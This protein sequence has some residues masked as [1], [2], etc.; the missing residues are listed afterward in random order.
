M[1]AIDEARIVGGEEEGGL[2]HLFR[3]ADAALL[4]G[5]CRFRHIDTE[6]LQVFHLAKPVRRAHEAGADGVAADVA[7]AEF[8]GDGAGEHVHGPFVVS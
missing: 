8:D 4:C 5:K 2:G 7:V 1:R 6:R 3:L